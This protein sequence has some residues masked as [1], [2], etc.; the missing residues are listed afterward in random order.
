MS[1]FFSFLFFS[2]FS[3]F[4]SFF[5]LDV[6]WNAD[7]LLLSLLKPIILLQELTRFSF[8]LCPSRHVRN[9][10]GVIDFSFHVQDR[11]RDEAQDDSSMD[12]N[13]AEKK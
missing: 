8:L 3:F 10:V 1:F 5:I 4:S 7:S 9:L 13:T 2:L 6:F 11:E 12:D